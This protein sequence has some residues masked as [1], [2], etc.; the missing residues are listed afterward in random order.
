MNILDGVASQEGRILIMTTNHI[1]K[2]DEA[3]IR[4]GRVD[5][6]IKF[7]LAS[8][9]MITTIFR[10]IYATLEG[11]YH[12]PSKRTMS[13]INNEANNTSSLSA[14]PTFKS[15]T[16][17]VLAP[18]NLADRAREQIELE[19]KREREVAKVL[20]LAEEFGTIVSSGKFSPAEIQ[21]Y[22]LKHKRMPEEAV[23]GA[24]AWVEEKDAEKKKREEERK[25]AKEERKKKNE[26]K[27]NWWKG[28]PA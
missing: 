5:M 27:K 22:L 4:P 8:T 12:T 6:T 28:R 21:G 3:L 14:T 1:K 2:L 18:K 25:K 24:A 15:T 16:D 10:F 20:V 26:R 17:L 19:M 11:D 13:A 23:K 7:D 9:E